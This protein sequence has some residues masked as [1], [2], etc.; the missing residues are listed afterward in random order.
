[1]KIPLILGLIAALSLAAQA[2]ET[3]AQLP[4][5]LPAHDGQPG[6][7]AKPVQVFIL[8]GQSNM[9]GMGQINPARPPYTSVHYSS[10]HDLP[11][12]P[13][14]I[15]KVG[16]HKIAPLPVYTPDGKS[17]SAP[18]ATGSFEI[19]ER[20]VYHV[21][22]GSGEASLVSM[23]IDGRHAYSRT[24]GEA[25]VRTELTLK[26]GK[27]YTFT[28]SGHDGRPP[29]FWLQK[30]DLTGYGDL[31]N[32]VTK[33]GLFPW[34]MDDEGNWVAR[35]DVILRDARLDPDGQGAPLLPTINNRG[36]T[37]GPEL[38]FG[39]A[40]GSY[41]DET[42]LII[43]TAQGNRSLFHDFR[44]PSSGVRDPDS[45]YESAEYKLMIEGVRDTLTNLADHVPGYQGQGYELAGFAWWQGHKDSGSEETID[46]YEQHLVHLINDVRKDLKAPELPVV[47][48]G[49]GFWGHH[50]PERY[51][52]IMDAQMA[53]GDPAKHPEYKG[54]V[55]SIDTRGYWRDVDQSPKGE[56]YHYN[57]NA[58]TYYRV[59]DA[60]AR[61]MI[62][63]MGGK[64]EPLPNPQLT[65][66]PPSGRRERP[67][68]EQQAVLRKQRAPY[69]VEN[70]IPDFVAHPANQPPLAA[71][72]ASEPHG[73]PTQF[74]DD[75][76]DDLVDYY[77]AAGIHQYD[78][79]VYAPDLREVEWQYLSFDP[80]ETLHKAKRPRY[81]N[82]TLPDGSENWTAPD[83]TPT[84]DWKTGLPPFGQKDGKLEPLRDCTFPA[85]GCGK[86]PRTLWED[87]VLLIRGTFDI[88]ALKPGHRYRLV[89]GGSAHVITGE[90]YSVHI[91]GKPL[92]EST[93]GVPNRNGARPRGGHIYADFRDEFDGGEVTIA[94]KSFLQYHKRS[95][96]PPSGHLSVWLEEQKLPPLE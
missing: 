85:C 41:F 34:L 52:G 54:N 56:D 10:N 71:A 74:L 82:I 44:P 87:E 70:I 80:P 6:D 95:P 12:D 77:N 27:N 75:R 88:P 25:P 91:N 24:A 35:Q 5:Q 79:K 96:I 72:A 84:A 1:M 38:G 3:P 69:L 93:T 67:S 29:H 58:E 62:D 47:V 68:A 83:F 14:V 43:K 51:R 53:V 55:A 22:C 63:L 50:M 57:R 36:K 30:L 66:A 92:A 19:P 26:P 42:V 90:G 64:A 7:P 73:R 59:G 46:A 48:A 32:T 31:T 94:V 11:T 49:V 40:V 9:V 39:H 21:Q 4:A 23:E 15:Y 37:V 28:I 65:Q 20:G 76:L 13:L 18:N 86:P 78:W 81:R 89:V 8:A 2:A 45:D 61:A 33:A 60:L 16:K 17:A